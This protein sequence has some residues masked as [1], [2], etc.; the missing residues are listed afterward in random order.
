M[1]GKRC[2]RWRCLT[3]ESGTTS[4]VYLQITS[5][6]LYRV[7][8]QWALLDDW[9]YFSM[10]LFVPHLSGRST[11]PS[12]EC[13]RFNE[14]LTI[15]LILSCCHI[16]ERTG[17]GVLYLLEAMLFDIY[18]FSGRESELKFILPKNCFWQRLTGKIN[19]SWKYKD[20]GNV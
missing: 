2:T 17:K 20:R 18:R 12:S 10:A 8:S 14:F 5:S 15:N 11:I 9:L 13:W 19:Y 1:F 16:L 6:I 7:Y 4:F 3:W